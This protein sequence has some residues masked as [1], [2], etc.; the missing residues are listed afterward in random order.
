MLVS[1]CLLSYC[2]LFDLVETFRNQAVVLQLESLQSH[3]E[4]GDVNWI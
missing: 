4:I 3:N 2:L 1:V